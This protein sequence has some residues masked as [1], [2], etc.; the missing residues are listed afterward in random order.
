MG[1]G[2]STELQG[3]SFKDGFKAGM[4]SSSLRYL[5]NKVVKFDVDGRHGERAASFKD[6]AGH[7]LVCLQI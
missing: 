4:I 2:I 7:A 3:G 5:Y 1:S 6:D